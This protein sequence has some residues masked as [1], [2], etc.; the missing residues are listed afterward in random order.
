MTNSKLLSPDV[1]SV[2]LKRRNYALLHNVT[3]YTSPYV[4][5]SNRGYSNSSA[6]PSSEGLEG[7]RLTAPPEP[8]VYFGAERLCA[9]PGGGGLQNN[10]VPL[11]L[12]DAQLQDAATGLFEQSREAMSEREVPG[13]DP[14]CIIN[15]TEG[16][17]EFLRMEVEQQ[18]TRVFADVAV[19]LD[20]FRDAMELNSQLHS[21]ETDLFYYHSDH[22][23]SASWITDGQ[24]A[25]MQHLQYCP[26]GEPFVDEHVN[27]SSFQAARYTFS[28]KERD[29]E[30]GY[31]NFGARY[32]DAT[33]LTSWFSV[34]PMADKYPS[35]SPYNY[36]AWNPIKLIDPDGRDWYKY[37][38]NGGEN[39]LWR[40]GSAK[41]IEYNGLIYTNIGSDFSYTDGNA[42]YYYKGQYLKSMSVS[43]LDKAHFQSQ[44]SD[45]FEKPSTAC[46]AA[47]EVMLGNV[48]IK[49]AWRDDAT[50]QVGQ[51]IG[52]ENNHSIIPTKNLENGNNILLQEV[53]LNGNP[54]IVGVDYAHGKN[55]N[56]GTTDHWIVI[57]GYT[58]D[59]ETGTTS[60][61]YFNPGSRSQK[62]G[63]NLNQILRRG[64]N[65]F[66]T[67]TRNSGKVYT[68]TN[69]RPNR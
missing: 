29:E 20:V 50:Q 2:A 16:Y 22:L 21:P 13:N 28:G 43:V 31:S 8:F 62:D 51:E 6:N 56:E 52:T 18:A 65:G 67:H 24:G 35:L 26:Y 7:R 54:V 46:K 57:S 37:E 61:N 15:P 32:L 59:L 68:V 25:P 11:F 41:T 60:Y 34:D 53:E 5:A 19:T 36:C 12:Q 49:S 30:T 42:T 47:C 69:I 23:G 17:V 3:L 48:G 63:T 39:V 44:F 45:K 66:L 58:Y 1:I 38:G 27:S 10:G 9:K 33:L 4:V 64:S 55:Y 40:D 14:N